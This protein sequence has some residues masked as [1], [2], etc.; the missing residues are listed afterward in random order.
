MRSLSALALTLLPLIAA[1]LFRKARY[2]L[3]EYSSL[4]SRGLLHVI[5]AESGVPVKLP[6]RAIVRGLRKSWGASLET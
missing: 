5:D 1:L 6:G 2:L 4:P 3:Q